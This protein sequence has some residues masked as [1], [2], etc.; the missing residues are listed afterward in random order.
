MIRRD[1]INCT[2]IHTGNKLKGA[3]EHS[4]AVHSSEAWD[5]S[6]SGKA[7]LSLPMTR[8]RVTL[9]TR[10]ARR[11]QHVGSIRPVFSAEPKQA[12]HSHT[13]VPG[14]G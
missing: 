8:V 13:S 14:D 12:W 11:A 4:E 3:Q 5:D 7:L 9:G 2:V 10:T 6:D 1:L